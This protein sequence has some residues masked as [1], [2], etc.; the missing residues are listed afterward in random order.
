MNRYRLPAI[1]LFLGL[2]SAKPLFLTCRRNP[3]HA[4]SHCD[5]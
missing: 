1:L 4:F 5:D 3:L 2:P